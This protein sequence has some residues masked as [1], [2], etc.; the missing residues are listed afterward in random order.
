MILL[1]IVSIQQPVIVENLFVKVINDK[2]NLLLVMMILTESL[3]GYHEEDEDPIL[4]SKHDIGMIENG[5]KLPK[6]DSH[7]R[8][9]ALFGLLLAASGVA[10]RKKLN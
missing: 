6:T 5:G 10:L 1:R 3:R 7:T 4:N 2:G 8:E 9:W